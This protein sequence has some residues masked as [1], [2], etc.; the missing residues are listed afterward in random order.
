MS[1]ESSP[2]FPVRVSYTQAHIL[3]I[4]YL[5]PFQLGALFSTLADVH[6]NLCKNHTFSSNT[7]V[8]M[9]SAPWRLKQLM[10]VLKTFSLIAICLG[11]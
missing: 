1:L 3:F 5:I 4:K 7:G 10:M 9:V 2:Y 6:L 11:L 8:S